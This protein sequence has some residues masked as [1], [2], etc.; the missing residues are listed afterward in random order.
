V[1]DAWRAPAPLPLPFPFPF[2]F[3][4]ACHEAAAEGN[5]GGG[6]GGSG[7][8]G[9]RLGPSLDAHSWLTRGLGLRLR[10]GLLATRPRDRT[11]GGGGCGG[12]GGEAGWLPLPLLLLPPS[13]PLGPVLVL[14]LASR[15]AAVGGGPG[16][17]VDRWMDW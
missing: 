17:S 15:G 3:P 11:D 6:G 4:F 12:C 16:W 10:L 2:P 1:E 5:G 13:P 7:G 8:D 9:C 14:V